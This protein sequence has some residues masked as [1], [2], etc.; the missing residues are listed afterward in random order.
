MS[1]RPDAAPQTEARCYALEQLRIAQSEIPQLT[2]AMVM[3]RA[4]VEQHRNTDLVAARDDYG[5]LVPPPY[6][7]VASTFSNSIERAAILRQGA[8]ACAEKPINSEEVL[9]RLINDCRCCSLLT[10]IEYHI[11]GN[12]SIGRLYIFPAIYL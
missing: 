5:N 7:I 4:H 1:G 9:A 11:S 2:Q 6:V 12:M 10:M 3:S 8:D